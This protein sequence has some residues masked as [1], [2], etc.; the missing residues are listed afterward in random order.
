LSSGQHLLCS[1]LHIMLGWNLSY[2]QNYKPYY[3][4]LGPN[5][6]IENF[7]LRDCIKVGPLNFNYECVSLRMQVFLDVEAYWFLL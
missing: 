2:I 1:V 3:I 4:S 5:S 6:Y 7:H